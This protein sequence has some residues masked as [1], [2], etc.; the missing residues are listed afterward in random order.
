LRVI[1]RANQGAIFMEDLIPKA[2]D[3]TEPAGVEPDPDVQPLEPDIVTEGCDEP[4]TKRE[5][6]D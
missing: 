4:I 1:T 6:E 5:A 2:Q 3:T